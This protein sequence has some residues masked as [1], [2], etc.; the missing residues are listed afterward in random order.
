MVIDAGI[1]TEENLKLIQAKGYDY[2]CVSRSKIKDYSIDKDGAIR[3][4]ITKD[5]Q[6]FTLQ[7]VE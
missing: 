5:N 4:L 1:A 3:H 7:K 2:V 6:F